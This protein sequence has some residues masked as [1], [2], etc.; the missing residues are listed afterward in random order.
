MWFQAKV[1]LSFQ[2]ALVI[3]QERR[4]RFIIGILF[5]MV[6]AGS[7]TWLAALPGINRIGAMLSAILIAVIYRNVIGYPE[8]IREGIQFS[9]RYL[10]RFAIILYGFKLNIDMVINK[11]GM[12][13]VY[14]AMT[15]VIAITTTML[16]AK[17][18]KADLNLSLLLGIGTGVCGAAAIA[19]VSPILKANDEDT[20]ISA[21]IIALIGTVFALTY[22]FLMPFLPM[23]AV[24]YGIWSGVSLHEIAHVAA[25]AMPAGQDVL[26][27]GLLAKLGRVFLLIPLSLILSFW[28]KRKGEGEGNQSAPFPWFLAGFI[29]TS[30]MGTYLPIPDYVLNDISKASTFLLAAAMVGLGLNVHLSSLRTRAMRPLL[31]MIIASIVVSTVSFFTLM[32]F[33]L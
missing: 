18:F 22:T 14:D 2:E 1:D 21:G 10:M 30:L 5:T 24:Q 8:S 16:L 28:M 20:A 13:L 15:I 26:A 23:S 31:A 29:M 25:A 11:G 4:N 33:S 3:D 19:A 32:W 9:A 6:V 27:M 7:G 12:L 17:L